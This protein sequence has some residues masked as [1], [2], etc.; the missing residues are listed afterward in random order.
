MFT[1]LRLQE[2]V[3]EKC[4]QRTVVATP[5]DTWGRRNGG[6]GH[7]RLRSLTA[8][9]GSSQARGHEREAGAVLRLQETATRRP[10]AAG[11]GA[12]KAGGRGSRIPA[13]PANTVAA[14][15][16]HIG[17]GRPG[18]WDTAYRTAPG[19]SAPAGTE[20]ES[21]AP[22]RLLLTARPRARRAAPARIRG[23]GARR[24]RGLCARAASSAY[25]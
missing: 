3:P 17:K 2:A 12:G 10:A 6:E 4:F 15:V 1:A 18:G 19:P 13:Q 8:L 22:P 16:G 7:I 21:C 20:V 5:G 11:P 14:P 23:A 24:G 25:N 9:P